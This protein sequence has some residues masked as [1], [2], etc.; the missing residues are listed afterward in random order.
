M[1]DWKGAT[2]LKM[3][4]HNNS[5]NT[6]RV[7]V[8]PQRAL[9]NPRPH[10]PKRA[11][12]TQLKPPCPSTSVSRHA[13]IALCAVAAACKLCQCRPVSSVSRAEPMLWLVLPQGSYSG[14]LLK[15]QPST[16]R[17]VVLAEGIWYANGVALSHDESFVAV[18]ETNQLR[19]LRYWL[20]GPKVLTLSLAL[21]D[22]CS[23]CGK[24]P[25]CACQWLL[26]QCRHALHHQSWGQLGRG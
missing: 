18:V 1:Y 14:R 8:H 20:K 6:V 5:A 15:Y 21:W 22:T 19:V 16:G 26:P 12:A 9:C 13:R 17:T 10:S 4:Q 3:W 7:H 11:P 24:G 23:T 25:R 2:F